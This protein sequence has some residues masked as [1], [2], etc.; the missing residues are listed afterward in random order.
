MTE[1]G[2]IYRWPRN[3][4]F[5]DAKA[6]PVVVIAPDAATLRTRR[7]VVVALSSDPRLKDHPLTVAFPATTTNGLS[8]TSFAMA[9]LPTTVAA[10]QLEGPIGR[11]DRDQL[12]LV[13]RTLRLALDLD[14][15]EPWHSDGA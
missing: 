4:S 8:Q 6:R 3:R 7:W 1:R 15:E 12:A 14:M 9:W 10:E 11:I 2:R 5:G 13:L